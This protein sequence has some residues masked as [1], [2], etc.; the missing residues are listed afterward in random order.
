MV[1][2]NKSRAILTL[3]LG[4]VM[5]FQSCAPTLPAR[6]TN[7]RLPKDFPVASMIGNAADGSEAEITWQ[8]FFHDPQLADLINIALK[9]NQ[10]LAILEQE[11]NIA[12][13]E[14]MS[15]Q[16]EYLPKFNVFGSGGVEK[17]ERFSSEDANSPTRFS[18][19]GVNMSWELDI[20]KKLRNA[21]KAAYFEYLASIEGKRYIVTNLVA[22]IASTYFE[23]IALDN[24]QEI[25]QSY[26][27]LLTQIKGMVD[28]QQ[29]AARITSLPVKRFEAEVLKNKSR[30][31]EIQQ[32][33]AVTSNKLNQLLGRFPQDIPRNSK[34]FMT[35]V[36]AGI[37]TSVPTKL[38]DNRPDVRRSILEMEARKLNV[39]VARARFYPSL[40]IDGEAGYENFNSKHFKGGIDPSA[41]FYGIAANITAP[42]LNRKAIKADYFSADNR[43]VQ[44]IYDYEKTLIKA[45][46]EVANQLVLLK[47][48]NS[49]LN[50]KEKQVKALSEAIEISNTLFRAARVDYV[51]ALFT[52]RDALEAQIDLI[53]I[54]KDQLTTS[55]NL[56]KALGGGWKGVEEKRP[57]SNY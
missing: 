25:V 57:E 29:K 56:Y 13:N 17:V 11:I 1:N 27:E 6:K 32:Q 38:L 5:L 19:G 39:D 20:W 21:S 54:K 15:R 30:K 14:V 48:Y 24:Q 2:I 34:E 9:N 28:L 3:A 16:G 40:S 36:F 50:L 8:K 23:L 4:G 41:G 33:I 10:E 26:I 53:D 7:M 18:R 49:I 12:N 46:G 52:Q 44:A 55:V 47:N 22:E 37:T 45:Y 43:Q 42:I 31:F 51:E 35:Y